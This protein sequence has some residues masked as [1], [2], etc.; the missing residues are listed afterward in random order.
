MQSSSEVCD[1]VA[2]FWGCIGEADY[3]GLEDALTGGDV[4]QVI[5]SAPGEGHDDREGWIAGFRSVIGAMPGLRV[6]PGPMRGFSNDDV[7]YV[8][9]RPTWHLPGDATLT[10]RATFV[11]QREQGQWKLVHLHASVGVPDELA[12]QMQS[13]QGAAAGPA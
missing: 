9:G 8:I 4:A 11:L 7:G 6:D 1:A 3:A 5:G 2:R 13:E 12:V 10:M